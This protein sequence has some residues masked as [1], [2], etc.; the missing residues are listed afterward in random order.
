MYNSGQ[1]WAAFGMAWVFG[2]VVVLMV[3]WHLRS[4][5]RMERMTLIHQERMKAIEKG[6]AWPTCPT[7][8]WKRSWSRLSR[9]SILAGR[10]DWARWGISW[11]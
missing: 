8:T 6:I 3:T 7:S 10:S 1:F 2:W 5:R 9:S 11:P 4:K